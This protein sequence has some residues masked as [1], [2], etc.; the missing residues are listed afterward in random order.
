MNNFFKYAAKIGA[1]VN[2][3]STGWNYFKNVPEKH[4]RAALVVLEYDSRETSIE[5]E[6]IRKALER[7]CGRYGYTIYNR[8]GYPGT[9]YFFV[10]RADEK[11]ELSFHWEF[12]KD[13]VD[14]CEK[15]IH[16][17]HEGFY[18]DET[19]AEFNERLSGIMEFYGEEYL[20]AV[21]AMK[22][23]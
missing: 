5:S 16:L 17:R 23:A 3:T 14:A 13:S 22:T 2:E 15:Q 18:S 4:F 19:D 8:S 20:T 10:M 11:E 7:Y 21:K 9:Q 12:V 6:R 1:T